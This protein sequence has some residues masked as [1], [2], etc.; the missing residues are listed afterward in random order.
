[1]LVAQGKYERAE[2]LFRRAQK[3]FEASLGPDSLYVATCVGNLAL[4]LE[5]QVR[6]T[7][8]MNNCL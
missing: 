3:I 8:T 5:A 1:M 4:L 2:P 6:S 7:A